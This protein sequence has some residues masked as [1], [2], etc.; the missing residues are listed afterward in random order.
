MAINVV[1]SGAAGRMGQALIRCLYS[2]KFPDLTLSGALERNDHPSLG[3]DIVAISGCGTSGVLL[4]ADFEKATAKGK[5]II[6]FSSHTSTPEYA[7]LAGA[8]EKAMVIGTT[9]LSEK[10]ME[11][12][13][14]ASSEIPIVMAPNMSLGINLLLSL[15]QQAATALKEKGYDI[16]V[17]ERHHR[18]KKDAPSGTAIGLGRAAANALGWELDEVCVHGRQGMSHGERPANQIGFHAV[19][20]GDIVG[21]HTV[22]FATDG[23]CIELSHRA[24]SRD[25]FAVGALRAA[26][27]VVK[28]QPGLYS[29]RDV[30]GL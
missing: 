3:H 19:R 6:D 7:K 12:V 23:E 9:G 26:E 5:V 18:R 27:W 21:D 17:I 8:A 15:T 29:M 1:I 14:L 2:G 16:E 13:R 11:P 30:L 25:T 20:G 10:E 4:T 28:Q 24:T 22:L